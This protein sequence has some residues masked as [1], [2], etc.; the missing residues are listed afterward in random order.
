MLLKHV[1][2]ARVRQD[3]GCARCQERYER[4]GGWHSE[5]DRVAVFAREEKNARTGVRPG[6][7]SDSLAG[8]AKRG[9]T[10]GGAASR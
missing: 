5:N 3:R 7:I 4:A 9:M 2:R 1:A 8:E 10:T 6:R